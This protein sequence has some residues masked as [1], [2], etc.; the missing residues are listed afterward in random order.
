VKTIVAAPGAAAAIAAGVLATACTTSRPAPSAHPGQEGAWGLVIDGQATQFSRE[1]GRYV[2]ACTPQD[3]GRLMTWTRYSL[4]GSTD[5]TVTAVINGDKTVQS[6]AVRL[7]TGTGETQWQSYDYGPASQPGTAA[8][9]VGQ[10]GLDYH[11][12]GTMQ[13]GPPPAGTQSPLQPPLHSFDLKI[14]CVTNN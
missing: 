11:I 2:S 1:G 9:V 7:N 12:T 8:S 14:A 3:S 6:L 13:G 4:T 10:N 5:G